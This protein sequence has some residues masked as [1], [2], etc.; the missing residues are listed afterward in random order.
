[1]NAE[2]CEHPRC[3]ETLGEIRVRIGPRRY[4]SSDCGV[5]HEPENHKRRIIIERNRQPQRPHF[6]AERRASSSMGADFANA[7]GNAIAGKHGRVTWS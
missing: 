7:L 5:S 3:G 6:T 1:M 2:I 4:C